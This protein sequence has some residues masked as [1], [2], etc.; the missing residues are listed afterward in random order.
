MFIDYGFT[1]MDCSLGLISPS[2]FEKGKEEILGTSLG[3]PCPCPCKQGVEKL[4][5]RASHVLTAD[6]DRQP[7]G[8][9]ALV[10]SLERKSKGHHT[11]AA[12][13]ERGLKGRLARIHL[14]QVQ[15][16]ISIPCFSRV[17]IRN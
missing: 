11:L 15:G 10:E 5:V 13:L 14:G 1:Y 6:L 8:H 17:E 12:G 7:K 3:T 4:G 16:H 9:H 2:S